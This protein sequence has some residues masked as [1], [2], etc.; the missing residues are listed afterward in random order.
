MRIFSPS[1]LT[2]FL[3]VAGALLGAATFTQADDGYRLWLRYEPI[4]DY[5]QK[6]ALQ[7]S[8]QTLVI[9]GDT[10][11]QLAIRE[12]LQMGL[13]GMLGN[14]PV[15]AERPG[16]RGGTLLVGTP[17]SNAAIAKLDLGDELADLGEEGY[18]LRHIA[19]CDRDKPTTVI[20]ANTD[21]GALYGT[22][23]FLRHLQMSKPLAELDEVS[24][25]RIKVRILNHWDNLTGTIERVQSG[26]SL[27]D[28]FALPDIVDP[29]YRDYARANASIGVNGS[30]LTNVNANALVLTRDYLEKVAAIA[31]SFRP[32]GVK[33]YLTARFSAPIEIGGLET[34]DPT[35]PA[36]QEWWNQKANEIYELIPDFGGFAVKANSEGQPGPQ[37]YGRSHA[38]GANMLASAVAPHGGIV[39][40]RAFVYSHEIEVDRHKQGF[41]E[42]VPL[43]GQFLPN[44][45]VQ[46]KNGAIDFMPREPFHPMFGAMPNTPLT[47]EVQ[48]TQEYLGGSYH[49]AFLG[50]LFQEVLEADT[51]VQGSG[52]TVASIIDG[53]LEGHSLSIMAGVS[54]VGDKRN[55]TGHPLLQSN[56][57]VFGRLAW[58][59][60]ID[61]RQ[62]AD[63]W[64]R[65]TFGNHQP[66]VDA[67][68]EMLMESREAVVDY[69]MPLGLHHI[70]ARGYHIGPGPWVDQGRPDWTAV[71]YHNATPQGV[72]FDRT[73]TGSNA[74]SQYAP[75]LAEKW[76][77][78][79]TIPE[80]LLLWFHHVPWDHPMQSGRTLWEEMGYVYQRGV[81]TVRSWR[82]TWEDLSGTIDPMRHSHVRAL[83]ARQER[84]A[85]E[86]KDAVLLY[87]QTF[88][89]KDWPELAEDPQYDLEHYMSIRRRLVPG[90]PAKH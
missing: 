41:D 60:Q 27:W 57:Y 61:S 45:S 43:D 20:A 90:D 5:G 77:N 10:E 85:M 66:T 22:F 78:L 17:E 84:E 68:V 18:L 33:V 7:Q 32:Y 3:I 64:T 37:D 72:G 38:E 16:Q 83:L 19:C 81:N 42:F 74:L 63:E 29:R 69:S 35:V 1:T 49:L 56:W 11:T 23:A 52:S 67:L 39:M 54:N 73:P 80:N 40:W 75:E 76:G 36:V 48:I 2:R 51:L 53:S 87:F 82:D 31:D 47:L 44:V 65:M 88:H 28:W 34:A 13:G 55:W 21:L 24:K 15:F 26:H 46:V 70:M 59:H 62:I 8:L 12:E 89:G 86:Y 50:P 79:E 71:Y 25:P 14:I 6:A 4:A 9:P 30:V 58:D